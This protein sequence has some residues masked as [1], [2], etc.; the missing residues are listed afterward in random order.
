MIIAQ[1]NYA[2]CVL[3]NFLADPNKTN[4]SSQYNSLKNNGD[5]F[6]CLFF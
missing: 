2:V 1:S 3:G 6:F 4:K 5:E